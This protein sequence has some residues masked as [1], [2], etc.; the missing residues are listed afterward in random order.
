MKTTVLQFMLEV[1]WRCA[2]PFFVKNGDGINECYWSV[3]LRVINYSRINFYSTTTI[4]P[5]AMDALIVWTN[6]DRSIAP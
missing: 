4:S 2:A 1:S 6:E 5:F 3:K